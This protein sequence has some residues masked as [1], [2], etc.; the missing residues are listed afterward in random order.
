MKA[1]ISKWNLS[2]VSPQNFKIEVSTKLL[3]CSR[4]FLEKGIQITNCGWFALR[5]KIV[6]PLSETVLCFYCQ[7]KGPFSL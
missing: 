2:G 1:T 4:V 7:S 5:Y 6:C 3:L